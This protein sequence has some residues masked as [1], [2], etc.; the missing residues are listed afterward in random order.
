MIKILR[1]FCGVVCAAFVVPAFANVAKT[2]GNNLTAYSGTG[3]ISNNQ[4]NTMMNARTNAPATSA[5]A[6]Y[7]NCNAV[8]LRCASPKCASGG[9]ADMGIAR[10]IVAGCVNSNNACK[11]YGDELID[12]IT[13]QVV[14]QSTAKLREQ[15]QAIAIAQANAEAQAAAASAAAEQSNAQMQQMQMQMQQMQSQMAE[16]MNAMREQMAAQNESQVAQIQT[17]LAAQNSYSISGDSGADM[18]AALEGL[19]VAEQLAIKNNVN[20]DLLVREQMGG[21]IQTAIDDAMTAMNNLKGKLDAVLEYAGCDAGA[22]SCTGPRRVKKFKELANA[23][24]DPYENVLD[25]TYDALIMAMSVGVDVNDAI[26]LLSDSCNLWG[27]YNCD[28]AP[29]DCEGVSEKNDC[30]CSDQDKKLCYYRVETENGKVN[31]KQSHC[32]LVKVLKDGEEVLREWVDGNSGIT[33]ATQVACASDA[34]M[35]FGLFKGRSKESPIGIDALRNLVN[36]DSNTG[37]CGVKNSNEAYDYSAC[38]IE[39]CAVNPNNKSD[40]YWEVLETAVQTKILPTK[41]T[42]KKNWCGQKSY[43]GTDNFE[44]EADVSDDSGCRYFSPAFVL[45][46]VHSHNIRFTEGDKP[47]NPSESEKIADMNEVIAYKSTVIAQ[48]LKKQYDALNSVIKRFKT[49]LEK[50]VLTSKMEM[51]TGNTS[52]SSGGGS[53]S[54]NSAGNTGLAGA[55]DCGLSGRADVYECVRRNLTKVSQSADKDR[56]NARKQLVADIKL[57]DVYEMCGEKG[58]C[59]ADADCKNVKENFGDAKTVKSCA[60]KMIQ[61]VN[62]SKGDYDNEQ[63]RGFYPR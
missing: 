33:G 22:N 5:T 3:A 12:Y 14:A 60:A 10:P 11:K 40:D 54:Y 24:F 41:D 59:A 36:T 44:V 45:C 32:R 42:A 7:G 48:Q 25:S 37:A 8:I 56:N 28:R 39:K 9:C 46:S 55:E 52:S 18:A 49:Q 21:Q 63:R 2:V 17:A 20:P 51:I 4:W 19:S 15:E 50:A 62:K 16:S 43:I 31:A 29:E 57:M 13:A 1:F 34:I 38:K 53:S 61:F 30:L 6:N 27:L 47:S 26:M 23:F 58:D 35:N